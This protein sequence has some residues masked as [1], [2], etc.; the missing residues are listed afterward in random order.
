MT[1]SGHLLWGSVPQMQSMK[2]GQRRLPVAPH[3]PP[4]GPREDGGR[5]VAEDP[6]PPPGAKPKQAP[7]QA[8]Q[9]Q[10]FVFTLLLLGLVP[11]YFSTAETASLQMK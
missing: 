11:A 8:E 10:P 3:S 5:N 6:S 9:N 1:A 2:S 4:P 7:G